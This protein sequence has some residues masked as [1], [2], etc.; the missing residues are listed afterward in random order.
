M[1]LLADS[2]LSSVENMQTI[3]G[4]LNL[5]F[6]FALKSNRKVALSK[7]DQQNKAYINIETL[8]PG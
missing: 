4:G 8:Q 6:I 7:A 2:W 5:D 1:T 3:K